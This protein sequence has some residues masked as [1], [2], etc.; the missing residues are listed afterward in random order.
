ME[1]MST[2]ELQIAERAR[3]FKEEPLTN[4]SQFI[5]PQMLYKEFMRLNKY[6]SAGTDGQDWFNYVGIAEER[7]PELL[8]EYKSGRYKAPPIR[9]VYIPK[10]KT[11]K[12]PLGIPTIEDK[13][14]QSAVRRVMEPIYEEIFKDFSYGFRPNSSCHKAIAYMFQ[15]VSFGGM[16]YII[17]ADIQNYF[18][19]INHGQLREFLDRRVKDGKIRKMLDK[20]LKAGI[21]EDET[22]SY[23]EEGTPQGGIVSP[24]LSN[25]YLHYV[26]D[27]WF[28]EVI[29]PRLK[30]RSFI[31]RYADDFVL[32]FERAEDANRVMGVLFKRFEKYFLR[33]HPGKTRLINLN[34]PERGNRSFDFLGLLI[35]WEKAEKGN[36]YSN[37]KRVRRNT[38]RL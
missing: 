20:W 33:L 17:D 38:Q 9:R 18:G 16:R 25:I 22:L 34:R 10:G 15:Q 27:E 5:T 26:L 14:L 2:V 35:T 30:G 24:L 13:V 7:L 28:S 31:V 23:P 11:D 19:S 12:R 1:E 32:G 36:L 29:Q 4:L 3:K 37:A 21:L 6:S 8:S